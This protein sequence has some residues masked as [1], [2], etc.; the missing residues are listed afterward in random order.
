MTPEA[1]AIKDE[2]LKCLRRLHRFLAQHPAPSNEERERQVR[3]AIPNLDA[4]E[5]GDWWIQNAMTERDSRVS[6]PQIA[7]Y[8]L[9]RYHGL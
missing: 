8:W 5:D 4:I 1:Q 3:E 9:L 6:Y 7:D 2:A